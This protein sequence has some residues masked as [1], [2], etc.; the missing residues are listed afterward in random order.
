MTTIEEI[1]KAAEPIKKWMEEIP[2]T[3]PIFTEM[4]T[5]IAN[6]KDYI[7]SCMIMMTVFI[8]NLTNTTITNP[9]LFKDTQNVLK[10]IEMLTGLSGK[11][12][13]HNTVQSHSLQDSIMRCTLAMVAINYQLNH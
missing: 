7:G 3:K 9:E 2:E 4:F 13:G 1:T 6:S 11:I 12:Q 10:N 5:M 8:D